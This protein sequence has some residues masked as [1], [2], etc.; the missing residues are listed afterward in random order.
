MTQNRMRIFRHV[1]PEQHDQTG[2]FAA[3]HPRGRPTPT[4]RKSIRL[5]GK[6][7]PGRVAVL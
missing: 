7:H 3:A 5:S 6:L 4:L 2:N 1:R